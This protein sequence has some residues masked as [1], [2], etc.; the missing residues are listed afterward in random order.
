M[1]TYTHH[2][3]AVLANGNGVATEFL[4]HAQLTLGPPY[5][6]I[7]PQQHLDNKHEYVRPMVASQEVGKLV[8]DNATQLL[9]AE[10][11][12]ELARHHH[13]CTTAKL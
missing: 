13:S 2:S 8:G 12:K 11:V 4:R 1:P 9:R 10:I 3:R 5:H 7:P 6:G